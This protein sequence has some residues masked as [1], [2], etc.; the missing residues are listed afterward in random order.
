MASIKNNQSSP[1][2]VTLSSNVDK[3]S[4]NSKAV[5]TFSFSDKPIGFDLS[6]I[7]V[8]DGVVTNLVQS[9]TAPTTFTADFM[10]GVNTKS[11]MSTIKLDGIYTDTFGINGTP[12]N[13][14][15]IKN[16]MSATTGTPTVGLTTSWVSIK[17]GNSDTTPFNFTVKLSQISTTP[18]TVKYTTLDGDAKGN[19]DYIPVSSSITFDPGETS[20][21]ITVNAIG[22]TTY[23]TNEYFSLKLTS[24]TGANLVLNGAEAGRSVSAYGQIVNDDVF[25]SSSKPSGILGTLN[26]DTLGGTSAGDLIDGKGGADNITGYAGNDIFSFAKSY[27]NKTIDGSALITDFKD[28]S[29][30]IGLQG[31]LKFSD[32]NITQGTAE[33]VN[34]T[35]IS[36][37]ASGDIL[38]TLVGVHNSLINSADFVHTDF[39]A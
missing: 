5:L 10:W 34:D 38:V 19:V 11:P 33:H 13:T 1:L 29:D 28:G 22:D 15:T 23:E 16:D 27:A 2:K 25:G 14:V 24:V 31:D 21:T 26:K 8:T 7:K 4:S 3:V 36:L 39:F 17:E 35:V 32:L 20:K 18:V 12:S 37:V 30:L 9:K 6:D